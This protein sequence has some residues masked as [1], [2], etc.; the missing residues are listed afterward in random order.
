MKE[1]K[2]VSYN[3]VRAHYAGE[4]G[5][6]YTVMQKLGFEI[7]DC[8]PQTLYDSIWFTVKD[9][10]KDMPNYISEMQYNYDY[11]H[12]KCWKNCEHFEKDHSCCYGGDYCL[13]SDG[14]VVSH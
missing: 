6:P 14:F 9:Y 13:K 11:W 12:N 5:N 7:I 10:I 4:D 1:Y 2:Q 8:V 3:V